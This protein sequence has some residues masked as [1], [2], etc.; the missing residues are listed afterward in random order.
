METSSLEEVLEVC[1]IKDEEN[2]LLAENY[3][4][5]TAFIEGELNIYDDEIDLSDLK[6]MMQ[7]LKAC[8]I[9][10]RQM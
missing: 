3:V 4:V 10:T 2:I 1:H 7:V 8:R 6:N 5:L 9:L